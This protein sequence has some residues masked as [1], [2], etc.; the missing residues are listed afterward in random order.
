[1][2]LKNCYYKSC[3]ALTAFSLLSVKANAQQSD[4]KDV[5]NTFKENIEALPDLIRVVCYIVGIGFGIA[6]L[7][8][9]KEYMDKP[10]GSPIITPM[11]RLLV[12]ALLIA[13]PTLLDIILESS[14]GSGGD[15]TADAFSGW[16]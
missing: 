4:I 10:G 15:V 13:L 5:T 11:G 9:L 6:G 7:M 12:A 3:A 14:T 1:M 16:Q 2:N 8:K